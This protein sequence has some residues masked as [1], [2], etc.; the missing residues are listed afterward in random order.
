M[1]IR[2]L[3]SDA[4][5]MRFIEN[6]EVFGHKFDCVIAAFT[7][8]LDP[9][10]ERNLNKKT[11]FFAIDTKYPRYCIEQFRQRGISDED[12]RV[13]LECPVDTSAGLVP[14]G[15]NRTLVVIEAI[16]R[17]VDTLFFADYDVYPTVLKETPDGYSVEAVDI[18]GAHL[19]HLNSGSQV[20]TGEYSGYNILPPA[21]F[22]G[23]EDLLAGLQKE[24]MLEYWQSSSAHRCLSLQPSATEPKP[25]TKIL[26][27][28]TALKL[29]AF[30]DLPPFFSSYHTVGGELYLNRG[31][32]TML[33]LGIA[34]NGITCTDIGLN[35]LH[36]TYKNYPDEPDFRGDPM[37]QDRFYYAC[38]GWVGRN[39]LLNY[40]RGEDLQSTREYQRGRLER[41]LQA[42]AE[43][44]SNPR[45]N[46]VM[47]NFDTSWDSLGRYISE[48]EGVLEAWDG[49]RERSGLK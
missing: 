5:L 33:G 13:L 4:E 25:C 21:M 34:K 17:G 7:Q 30:A 32:D 12:A 24:D 14:Y 38:T 35:P 9:R 20:T 47:R 15:F 16:L 36:D 40:M 19:D 43:Y 39:P 48:Y 1:I 45:Y 42:L 23:M 22:D 2:S 8:R 27:G 6:A 44:T 41:G 11:R 29:S 46:S 10:A 28:N 18:L 26:G 37:V 49:F 31:E 3:D